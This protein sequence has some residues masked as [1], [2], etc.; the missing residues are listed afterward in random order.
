MILKGTIKIAITLRE[1]PRMMTTVID[2]LMVNC[3]SAYNGALGRPLLRALKAITSI[4]CLTIKFPT[5]A[6]LVK[7]EED[8]ETQ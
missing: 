7:F 3:L 4:H 5:T 2:F 1:A 8:N 6:G